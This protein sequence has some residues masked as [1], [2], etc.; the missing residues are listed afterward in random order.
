MIEFYGSS[1][2]C[3]DVRIEISGQ[4]TYVGVFSR[5][6]AID[7][8]MPF[9]LPDIC[10]ANNFNMR[11]LKAG[12]NPKFII[13]QKTKSGK[14]SIL[15][16]ETLP[17]LPYH[18][19]KGEGTVHAQFHIFINNCMIEEPSELSA[20]LIVEDEPIITGK[21]VIEGSDD[22]ENHIPSTE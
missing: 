20:I 14:E 7:E 22:N 8:D 3:E 15:I 16:D 11:V 21:L 9:E 1:L 19:E 2:F 5:R 4:R 10:V 6:I 13:K 18:P 17:E 12:I